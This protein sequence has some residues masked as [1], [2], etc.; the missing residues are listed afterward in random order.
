MIRAGKIGGCGRGCQC[1][2]KNGQ[3]VMLECPE[4]DGEGSIGEKDCETCGGSGEVQLTRCSHEETASIVDLVACIEL[5]LD[6]GLA[7]IAGGVLD[8]AA[9]FIAAAKYYETQRARLR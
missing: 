9:W 6:H 2:G 4:C 5:F 1:K 3:R 8:Q 7:P